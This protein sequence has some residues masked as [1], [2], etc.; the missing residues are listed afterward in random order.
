MR[1]GTPHSRGFAARSAEARSAEQRPA[2]P[3]RARLAA[4][5]LACALGWG[6]PGAVAQPAP[7]AASFEENLSVSWVFVPVTVGAEGGDERALEREDFAL[8]VDE[9]RVPFEDFISPYDNPQTLLFFQDLSGSMANGGKLETSQAIVRWFLDR[10]G[11]DDQVSLTTFASGHTSVDVPITGQLEVVREHVDSWRAYGTTALHD[12]VTW[13]PEVRLTA[14]TAP[15]VILVTDGLDNA[16]VISAAKARDMVRSAEVPVYVVGLRRAGPGR[17]V[18]EKQEGA[19]VWLYADLLRQLATA[20]GG[21]Y[22]EARG[23][24]DVGRACAM[25]QRALR[26]RYAL[27]FRLAGRGEERYRSIRVSLPGKRLDLRHRAGYLGA[28]PD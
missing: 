21:L 17:L 14:R 20:T 15:A 9:R 5:G 24:A 4:A 25:I 10:A 23:P 2:A 1:D 13:V 11:A 27:G 26:S 8:H 18:R 19:E 12:A 22:V 7:P 3:R 6:A 28:A 16:S